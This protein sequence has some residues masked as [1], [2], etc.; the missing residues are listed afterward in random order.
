MNQGKKN[1]FGDNKILVDFTFIDEFF[2]LLLIQDNM[3]QKLFKYY[4]YSWN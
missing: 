1:V 2:L 3:Q 4:Y